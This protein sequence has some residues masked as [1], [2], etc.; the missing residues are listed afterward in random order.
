MQRIPKLIHL[1][2]FSGDPYPEVI[3]KCIHSWQ[4]VMPDYEIMLWDRERV[5][6]ISNRFLQEALQKRK[7]AF[8]ADFIRLYA[9]YHHGGIYM[10]SDVRAYQPFDPFLEHGFFSCIEYFKPTGYVAIEAAIMGA[11]KGHP[12]VGECLSIFDSI[13]FVKEDGTLD[14]TTITMRMAQVAHQN[15]GF[16]YKPVAQQ[17]R[18]DIM[19]YPSITFTNPSGKFSPQDTYA[20][21][22]CNGSWIDK[23]PGVGERIVRFYHNYKKRPLAGVGSIWHKVK[24]ITGRKTTWK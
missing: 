7:W 5:D 10:D 3:A 4:E 23:K 24:S 1:C 15:W 13:P 11:E 14:Q 16:E 2:W 6:Q 22:L 8:A 21:H 18:E 12:F 20:L 9:L 17:L 19:I